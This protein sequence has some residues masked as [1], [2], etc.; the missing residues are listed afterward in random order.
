LTQFHEKISKF[1]SEISRL[2][3]EL[4]EQVKT[5]MEPAAKEFFNKYPF[6]RAIAWTQYTPYFNDGEPCKFGVKDVHIF[7]EYE[8][9]K[10]DYKHITDQGVYEGTDTWYL[11]HAK[12]R[13]DWMSDEFAEDYKMFMAFQEDED[14]ME[15]IFGD[16]VQIWITPEGIQVDEYDHD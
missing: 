13:E 6:V 15:T 5:C 8:F 9:P 3:A 10:E 16:H 2:K 7:T 11:N 12:Y 1:R 14:T 4:V